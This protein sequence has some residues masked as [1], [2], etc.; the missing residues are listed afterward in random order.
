MHG[1]LPALQSGCARAAFLPGPR[2]RGR[3]AAVS[4]SWPW[5]HVTPARFPRH[6]PSAHAEPS[7]S[8]LWR[9]Q[10]RPDQPRKSP[11]LRTPNLVTSAKAF[12]TQAH[13]AAVS[14]VR[15]RTPRGPGGPLSAC[16][17]REGRCRRRVSGTRMSPPRPRRWFPG[18][19]LSVA[20]DSVPPSLQ[21]TTLAS[22][23]SP[24]PGAGSSRFLLGSPAF[25]NSGGGERMVA[26][27]DVV[28]QSGTPE[29]YRM[30]LTML[31]Q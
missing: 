9:Q 22:D 1:P 19:N 3:F 16:R 17:T 18:A 5:P 12:A 7:A 14:G 11:H 29:I 31:P 13:M 26:Y 20:E 4:G 6:S 27:T 15:A 2:G 25:L 10:T 28:L 24:S 30:L 21:M 23:S 8:R